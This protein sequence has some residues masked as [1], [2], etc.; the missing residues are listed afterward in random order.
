LPDTGHYAN[1]YLVEVVAV[2]ELLA[3]GLT[4]TCRA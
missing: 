1:K 4:P 3:S 2:L